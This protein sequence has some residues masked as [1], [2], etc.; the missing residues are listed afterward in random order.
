MPTSGGGFLCIHS[1]ILE[2]IT[3]Y[4]INI[5]SFY[6]LGFMSVL[7]SNWCNLGVKIIFTMI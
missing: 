7:D 1:S 6:D 3:D 5:R 4:Q 2:H